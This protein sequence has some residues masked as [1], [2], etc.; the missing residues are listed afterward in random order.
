ML[1][2]SAREPAGA[3]VR[4]GESPDGRS[5]HNRPW[6]R[7]AATLSTVAGCSHISVCIAGAKST[8]HRAVSNVAVR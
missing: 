1:I 7:R 8:G 3:V 5:Q 2:S 4:A 6:R